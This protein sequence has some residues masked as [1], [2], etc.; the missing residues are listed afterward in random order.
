MATP[1]ALTKVVA[2]NWLFAGDLSLTKA[3][4]LQF[5]KT[6]AVRPVTPLF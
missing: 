3:P 5:L 4:S 1:Y 6:G 2:A